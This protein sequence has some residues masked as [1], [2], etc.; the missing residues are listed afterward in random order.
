MRVCKELSRPVHSLNYFDLVLNHT[1]TEFYWDHTLGRVEAEEVACARPSVQGQCTCWWSDSAV[2]DGGHAWPVSLTTL[3]CSVVWGK[4]CVNSSG[5]C[6]AVRPPIQLHE[7]TVHLLQSLVDAPCFVVTS[8][9]ITR[10]H[11][12]LPY[13]SVV[14][15]VQSI[16]SC[17]S[18]ASLSHSLCSAVCLCNRQCTINALSYISAIASVLQF[19]PCCN[20]CFCQ[21]APLCCV[22]HLWHHCT[23][24]FMSCFTSASTF[25]YLLCIYQY[26]SWSAIQQYISQ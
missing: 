14:S 1:D 20:I 2:R 19:M 7:T 18:V 21:C 24:H 26:T 12:L 11:T 10:L 5:F 9:P 25:H 8:S 6:V 23:A 17:T 22:R 16:L 13:I 4:V 15:V 3:A